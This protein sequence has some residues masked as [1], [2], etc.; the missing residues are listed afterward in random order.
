MF[1][2]PNLR[3]QPSNVESGSGCMSTKWCTGLK[4]EKLEPCCNPRSWDS[5][6]RWCHD[7]WASKV[8]PFCLQSCQLHSLPWRVCWLQSCCALWIAQPQFSETTLSRIL[9]QESSLQVIGG[10]TSL[11]DKKMQLLSKDFIVA[12]QIYQAHLGF[13]AWAFG[14][15]CNILPPWHFSSWVHPGTPNGEP[16]STWYTCWCFS[17]FFGC[18]LPTQLLWICGVRRQLLIC[19]WHYCLGL[20]AH[21]AVFLHGS[22]GTRCHWLLFSTEGGRT[23]QPWD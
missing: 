19:L 3:I 10:V 8:T 6:Q 23:V 13:A 12:I 18:L 21:H 20:G 17:I 11:N 2:D 14:I 5:T 16:H 4:P 22:V 9:W 7:I 15:L 1:V